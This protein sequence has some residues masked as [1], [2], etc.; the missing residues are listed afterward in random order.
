[1]IGHLPTI[2]NK[3]SNGIDRS[4]LGQVLNKD[5]GEPINKEIP[6]VNWLCDRS[7]TRL[8][9]GTDKAYC[10]LEDCLPVRR[11]SVE[12]EPQK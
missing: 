9:Y 1:M 5:N 11:I 8:Q 12:R 6:F 4:P 3:A 7:G 10:M 2:P